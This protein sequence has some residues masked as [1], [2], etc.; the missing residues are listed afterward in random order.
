[1][2]KCYC[3]SG[4]AYKNCC[5]RYISGR[6]YPPTAEALMRSRFSAFALQK[7]NYLKKTV[8][9]SAVKMFEDLDL[10][11]DPRQWYKLEVIS[12][13]AGGVNDDIGKVG[14]KAY[15]KPDPNL[16]PDRTERLSERSLFKKIAGKWYYIGSD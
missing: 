14:F 2:K 13:S 6:S 16:Y 3:G 12:K 7:T 11:N 8:K 15:Y 4:L 1:M 10:S 9:L 5:Q